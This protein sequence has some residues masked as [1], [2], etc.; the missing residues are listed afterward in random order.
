MV[1]SNS[2]FLNLQFFGGA[3]VAF[4]LL[5]GCAGTCTG[6]SL[7][8][9][10]PKPIE[11]KSLVGTYEI[12]GQSENLKGC[13]IDGAAVAG[14]YLSI[15]SVPDEADPDKANRL[16]YNL[17]DDVSECG[18]DALSDRLFSWHVDD[19][20]GRLETALASVDRTQRFESLCHMVRH[21]AV[22]APSDEGVRIEHRTY[23]GTAV[24]EGD[25]PCSA[26]F[27]VERKEALECAS[28]RELVAKLVD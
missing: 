16:A 12:I 17:C 3:L 7:S 11:A 5:P 26:E 1:R 15:V 23:R 2:R 21:E 4:L 10:G 18:Q 24:L 9:S 27:V 8:S 22:L 13:E 6:C 19:G 20:V 25:E 28:I 14:T